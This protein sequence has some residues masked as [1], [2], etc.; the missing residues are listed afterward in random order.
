MTLVSVHLR[1]ATEIARP[2]ALRAQFPAR[3]GCGQ[4]GM[5]VLIRAIEGLLVCLAPWTMRTRLLEARGACVHRECSR[6]MP[7]GASAGRSSEATRI[8]GRAS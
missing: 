6:R 5:R 4:W 8:R 1:G 3:N 2:A 7:G